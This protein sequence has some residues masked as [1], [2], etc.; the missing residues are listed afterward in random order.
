MVQKL[1]STLSRDGSFLF[2]PNLSINIVDN[3]GV[4]ESR[5]FLTS[6]Q[7]LARC[8]ANS[9]CDL[10]QI[11]QNTCSLLLKYA[12]YHTDSNLDS[13]IYYNKIKS[14]FF[15]SPSFYLTF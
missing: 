12:V 5:K 7:C 14:L 3:N 6:F 15:N 8:L 1:M 11:N 2:I 4:I 13:S 10:I 9:N